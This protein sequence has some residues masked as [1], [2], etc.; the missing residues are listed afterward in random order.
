MAD[1]TEKQ[2]LGSITAF[3]YAIEKGVNLGTIKEPAVTLGSRDENLYKALLSVYSDMGTRW[4]TAFIKQAIVL[5]DW[6]GHTQGTTDASYKY[7]R[8]GSSSID[9]IPSSK[10]STLG[11][12]MWTNLTKDQKKLYGS[13]PKKDSWNPMDV[14][15]VKKSDEDG[16][17][18]EITESCCKNR[19]GEDVESA[20]VMEMQSLNEYLAYY[21]NNHKLVGISLKETDFGEPKVTENNLKKTFDHIH[22]SCG[23]IYKALNMNMTVLGSKTKMVKGQLVDKGMD[24][25]T[26]SLT[27]E[28]TFNIGNYKKSYKYES[29]ISSVENHATE[30]R[31]RVKGAGGGFTNAKARNGAVP[32]PKMAKIV[33]EYSGQEINANIPLK[34][35]FSDQD[36]KAM[37]K[38]LT[39]I[40]SGGNTTSVQKPFDFNI[41]LDKKSG[42]YFSRLSAK[43]YVNKL[44]ELDND[45]KDKTDKFPKALRSKFRAA[46]YILMFQ[47]A[48]QESENRLSNLIAEL[49][50]A[51]S[52]INMSKDDLSGPFIKI[53]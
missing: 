48:E 20:A 47:K 21:A 2:E 1:K 51:S 11:D 27:Y 32:A 31:D 16:I 5:L 41:H 33:K 26:N 36:K 28:A 44:V 42:K 7:G 43:E 50:F 30:P 19:V 52:K 17:K 4:Y 45:F 9:S 23:M 38:L 13:N 6:L 14:Y 34:G 46:R 53:Q 10:T 29:K 12:W 40:K 22:P 25:E 24:F 39:S 37:V 18:G 3:Y 35:N 49:Y 8:F 15:I